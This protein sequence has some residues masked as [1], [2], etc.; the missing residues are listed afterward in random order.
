MVGNHMQIWVNNELMTEYDDTEYTKGHFAIQGHN[1]GQTIE[2]K[3]LV[4]RDLSK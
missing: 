1:P 4:Y 3:E 2:I